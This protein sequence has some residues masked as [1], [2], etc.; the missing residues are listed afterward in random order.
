MHR[1][2]PT[3]WPS[4]LLNKIAIQTVLGY[5]LLNGN[6]VDFDAREAKFV[7]KVKLLFLKYKSRERPWKN[8]KNVLG[9]VQKKKRKS[10][11]KDK[12]VDKRRKIL[13]KT[14][15]NVQRCG[16]VSTLTRAKTRDRVKFPY[17]IARVRNSKS[18]FQ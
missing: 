17:T 8:V 12:G 13:F 3:T 14:C 9:T 11:Q 18:L 2:L 5:F 4:L 15:F 1:I 16:M 7:R 10:S 6:F